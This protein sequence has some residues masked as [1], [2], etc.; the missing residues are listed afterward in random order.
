MVATYPK[1]FKDQTD[2][3]DR[4]GCGYYTTAKLLKTRIVDTNKA[5]LTMRLRQVKS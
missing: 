5:S 3:G 4:L 1:S 2:D